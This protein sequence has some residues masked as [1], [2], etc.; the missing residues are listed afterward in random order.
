MLTNLQYVWL[1]ALF[2]ADKLVV[3]SP[4]ATGKTWFGRWVSDNFGHLVKVID[5]DAPI[6]TLMANP[7]NDH[8]VLVLTH[9]LSASESLAVRKLGYTVG[10]L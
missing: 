2:R 7:P 8:K 5:G 10:I 9:S 6:A 1:D 3:V 4:P